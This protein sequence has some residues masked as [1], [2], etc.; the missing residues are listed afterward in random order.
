MPDPQLR[1]HPFNYFL[2]WDKV[3]WAKEHGVHWLD[4]GGV[5]EGG[6]GDVLAPISA[7]KRHFAQDVRD[8]SREYVMATRPDLDGLFRGL[9]LLKEALRP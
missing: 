5:T 4:L 3:L 7:F 1:K 9:N 8:V 2:L 6:E